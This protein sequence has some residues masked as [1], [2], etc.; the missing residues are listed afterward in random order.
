M[1]KKIQQYVWSLAAAAIVLFCGVYFAQGGIEADYLLAAVCFSILGL[2]ASS[3][4]YQPSRTT[5]GSIAFLPI[6]TCLLLVPHWTGVLGITAS[7]LTAEFISR[8]AAIKVVFNTVQ[9]LFSASVTVIAYRVLGG[10]SLLTP[11]EFRF[12]PYLAAI[13]LF[14]AANSLTM[15]AIVAVQEEKHLWSLWV[16]RL[17]FT[18]MYDLLSI[19]FVFVFAYVYVHFGVIGAAIFMIPLLGARQLYKTNW[20]L[21]KTNQ[22]LLEL[23]VAAI[24]ARDPYTSGHSRMVANMTRVI[25]RAMGLREREIERIVVA[26]L[27]HDVGKIHEIFGPILSKP[28]K[29]TAEES[30]IMR[31]HPIKSEELA[32]NV[33]SLKDI[34]PLIRHHHENWDGSGYPD[35]LFGAAI[36]LGSRIVMFADTIDAM[37]TDRPYRTALGETAVRKELEKFRGKQFDP[38]IYDTLVASPLFSVLFQDTREPRETPNTPAR[39]ILSIARRA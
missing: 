20:Q 24:E 14:F 13:V 31:T 26:A 5:I 25:S 3:L 33:S 22:E 10:T 9:G 6:L 39:P 36:P 2:A 16:K 29:L 8:R 1:S 32:R 38:K 11:S 34:L 18:L 17:R 19:P 23:M 15:S 12:V 28:A 27:L 37:T 35:G 30:A 4:S 7:L 21:E